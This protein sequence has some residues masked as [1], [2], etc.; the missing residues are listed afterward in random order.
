MCSGLIPVLLPGGPCTLGDSVL[1]QKPKALTAEFKALKLAVGKDVLG[2]GN[3][4][5]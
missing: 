2:G 3:G 4:L 5:P 1:A